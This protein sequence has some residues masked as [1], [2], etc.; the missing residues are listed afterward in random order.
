MHYA[1][2]VAEAMAVAGDYFVSFDRK[3]LIDNPQA[4]GL[5]FP[6]GTAGD[7]LAWYRARLAR[8]DRC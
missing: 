2:V 3:H 1:Q 8:R 6:L 7:F 4:K 5:P